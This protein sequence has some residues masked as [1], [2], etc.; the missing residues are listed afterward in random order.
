MHAAGHQIAHHTWSHSDLVGLPI[1]TFNNEIYLTEMALRNVLGLVPTYGRPPYFSC[2][3]E[4]YVRWGLQGCHVIIADLDTNDWNFTTPERQQAAKD[5]FSRGLVNKT[6]ALVLAHDIHEQ[7]VRNLTR[8][9]LIRCGRRG[10]V[11]P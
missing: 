8:S 6:S 10:L 3:A 1:E 2:D 9:C 4:C 7:T 5:N 11:R